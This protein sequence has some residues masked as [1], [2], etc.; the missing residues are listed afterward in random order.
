MNSL[1]IF[2]ICFGFHNLQSCNCQWLNQ[3]T[4]RCLGN[5][6][7][8]RAVCFWAKLKTIFYSYNRKWVKNNRNNNY[9][10]LYCSF[11]FE[12]QFIETAAILLLRPVSS[13]MAFK[14]DCFNSILSLL[15][16]ST[17][18]LHTLFKVS[19]FETLYVELFPIIFLWFNS[20]AHSF[21]KMTNYWISEN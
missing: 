14:F 13:V 7:N 6:T 17:D 10:L 12:E 2:R 9:C 21:C 15:S 4:N 8:H 1:W 18:K 5:H 20:T 16:I 11:L 19:S 3:A